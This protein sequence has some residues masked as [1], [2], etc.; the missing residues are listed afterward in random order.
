MPVHIGHADPGFEDPVGLMVARHRRIERPVAVLIDLAVRRDG[1][2]LTGSQSSALEAALKYF[3]DAAPHHMADEEQSLCPALQ[4]ASRGAHDLLGLERGHRR[5]E[6]LHA[7]VNELGLTCLRRGT[8]DESEA[9][10]LQTAPADL[11]ALYREHIR[12]E[13]ERVFPLAQRTLTQKA[14]EKIG[15]DMAFRRGVS[16]I[17]AMVQLRAASCMEPS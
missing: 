3:R 10:K 4:Q 13:E 2:V 17:P 7:T 12:T 11:S 8:L 9:R 1:C 5:A 15:R 6:T 14:L 16:Y